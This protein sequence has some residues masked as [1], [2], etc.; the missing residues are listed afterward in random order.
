MKISGFENVISIDKFKFINCMDDHVRCSFSACIKEDALDSVLATVDSDIDF[1]NDDFKFTGHVTAVAVSNDISGVFIEV[2]AIGKSYL[3]DKDKYRRVFQQ[4][5]KTI[6]DILS[7]MKSMS[8]VEFQSNDDPTVQSIIFQNDETEWEFI[9]RLV[10]RFG[11]HIFNT[12]KSYIGKF[13][14]NQCVL[15][16]EKLIDYRTVNRIDKS[17]IVCRTD[18]VIE[19]GSQVKC[20]G[21]QYFVSSQKY[22]LEKQKYYYEYILSEVAGDAEIQEELVNVY[23]YAK[24]KDNN[25]PDKKGRLQVDFE[26]DGIEDCM[27]DSPTWVDRLDFY[28]NKG[29]G[30]VMIPQIDDIV[31]VHLHNGECKV[32]GCL[33]TESYASPYENCDCKYLLLSEETFLQ[34]EDGK[35]IIKNKDSQFELL[36]EEIHIT[37]GDKIAI[38]ATKEEIVIRKDKAVVDITSDINVTTGKILVEAKGD[39]S[40]TGTNVNIK[41]KSGVSVN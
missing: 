39:A 11:L 36:G 20:F 40:I 21:K 27:K 26:N 41:G 22:V 28:S 2:E 32:V 30:P 3:C 10:N 9:K 7:Q 37:V 29:L 15:E 25:D 1:E 14:D 35:M 4:G 5:D 38:S 34:Y 13:R 18:T 16:K 8:D 33:R 12:D 31:R 24:V 19:I 17:F 23:L 6:S